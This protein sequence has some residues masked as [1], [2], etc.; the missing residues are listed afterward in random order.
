MRKFLTILLMMFSILLSACNKNA[1]V[2]TIGLPGTYQALDKNS[3]ELILLEQDLSFQHVMKDAKTG[4]VM[5][6]ENGNYK[7]SGGLIIFDKFTEFYSPMTQKINLK[8]DSFISYQMH[9]LYLD[10]IP[11]IKPDAEQE[12][13]FKRL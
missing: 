3:I 1:G 4:N 13:Y 12:Y 11:E 6:S 9:I 5:H 10:G 8:G 2:K 7:V